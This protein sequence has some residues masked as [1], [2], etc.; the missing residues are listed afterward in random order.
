MVKVKEDMTGWNMWEHGIPDS[1][2]TILKQTEDYIK[3]NG[4]HEAQYLCLCN[5]DEHNI[6][7]SRSEYLK[8]GHT[9]SCGCYQKDKARNML[10]KY[11]TYDLSNEYSIGYCSNTNS[12]FYF[13]LEDYD[14]IKNYC[15][16]E[17]VDPK[18]KYHSLRAYDSKSKKH[19]YMHHL[20]DFKNADHIDRNPLNNQK[21]NLRM[22]TRQENSFNVG[23]R[24]NNTSGFTGVYWSKEMHKW[25]ASLQID[26]KKLT[27]GYF[28][29]KE[30]AI[31]ARLEA[32]SK[33]YRDFAPQRN[34]F[35]QY[36]IKLGG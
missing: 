29:D 34:L 27:L 11:N 15:W 7:T 25:C 10:K 33:Y 2:L 17:D 1:K 8:N 12:E 9:L 13:D 19:I 20:F 5:C 28:D 31:K 24:S 21:K 35:E 36:G 18:T 6:I 3:P 26:N 30:V 14:K 32:E 23:L 4:K 22:A 16:Y